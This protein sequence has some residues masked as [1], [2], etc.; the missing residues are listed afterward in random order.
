MIKNTDLAE[1]YTKELNKI[2]KQYKLYTKYTNS[3]ASSLLKLMDNLEEEIV[4][5][6]IHPSASDGFRICPIM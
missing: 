6:G 3:V 4:A 1:Q 5:D 2:Y